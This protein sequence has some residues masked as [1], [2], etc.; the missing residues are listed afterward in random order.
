MRKA[1]IRMA[2]GARDG[3][4]QCVR[5]ATTEGRDRIYLL[6]ATTR[7]LNAALEGDPRCAWIVDPTNVRPARPNYA[8]L[9]RSVN[10]DEPDEGL[11][12]VLV[13]EFGD[14]GTWATVYS[15]NGTYHPNAIANTVRTR[16]LGA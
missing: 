9:A 6:G 4:G 15:M 14:A 12:E 7:T 10:P 11:G 8:D 13:D 1:G 2:T 3:L 5:D 16:G